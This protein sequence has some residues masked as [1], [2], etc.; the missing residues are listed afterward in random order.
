MIDWLYI[1][2]RPSQ[3]VNSS[4]HVTVTDEDLQN[5]SLCW[6]LKAIEQAWDLYCITPAVTWGLGFC[7][8]I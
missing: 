3:N 2:L 1:V 8:L 6:A 7:G 4:G 5:L